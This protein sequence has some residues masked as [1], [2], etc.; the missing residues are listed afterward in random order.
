V[1]IEK[2]DVPVYV[3]ATREDHIVPWR[4][5]YATTGLVGGNARFVLGSSGH[6]AGVINPPARKKRNY[7]IDGAAGKDPEAWL[8]T[9]KE[10]P[11]SWWPDWSQ[12]LKR[13]PPSCST[14]AAIV[15]IDVTKKRRAPSLQNIGNAL[16][17]ACSFRLSLRSE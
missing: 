2:I 13:P 16:L 7:W 12:W 9:A 10:V 1:P 14:T 15:T 3:L 6:I 11:G 5:A 4:T 8:A 17:Q